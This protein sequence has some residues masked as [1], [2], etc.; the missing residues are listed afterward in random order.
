MKGGTGWAGLFFISSIFFLSPNLA[1]AQEPGPASVEGKDIKLEEVFSCGEPDKY[2]I[3]PG[4]QKNGFKAL[5]MSHHQLWKADDE[6]NNLVVKNYPSDESVNPLPSGN[7]LIIKYIDEDQEVVWLEDGTGKKLRDITIKD[8]VNA[9]Y[10]WI[11]AHDGSWLMLF[12]NGPKKIQ[13]LVY[14]RNGNLINSHPSPIG[15]FNK[16]CVSKDDQLIGLTETGSDH[17]YLLDKNGKLLKK[18][19]MDAWGEDCRFSNDGKQ[20]VFTSRKSLYIMDLHSFEVTQIPI[21]QPVFGHISIDEFSGGEWVLGEQNHI[22]EISPGTRELRALWVD[23]LKRANKICVIND[24]IVTTYAEGK[25][26]TRGNPARPRIS[27]AVL[28]PSGEFVYRAPISDCYKMEK[29]GNYLFLNT[30][31]EFK[32][33]KIKNNGN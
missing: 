8:G 22:W 27:L 10:S 13:T 15:G 31:K 2:L 4:P 23:K 32:I 11:C 9:A 28:N 26:P 5:I 24:W 17:F 21:P 12:D 14:D 1:A 29:Q 18:I 33:F 25:Y 19:K 3:M 20:A 16:S 7:F 30:V 6:K